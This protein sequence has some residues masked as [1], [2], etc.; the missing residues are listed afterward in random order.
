MNNVREMEIEMELSEAVARETHGA[1][2][3]L[4]QAISY[5][6][7]PGGARV[8]PKLCLAVANACNPTPPS[9]VLGAAVATEFLHCA[10]LVHDDLPCLDNAAFRRGRPSVHA[11]FG[12]ATALLVGDALISMAFSEIAIAAQNGPFAFRA[13]HALSMSLGPSR[14]LIA[15]QAWEAEKGALVADVHAAKTGSLFRVA[16]G[17][18]ALFAGG[19]ESAFAKVGEIVGLIYQAGDDLADVVATSQSTGKP[20]RQDMRFDRP[21]IV[22]QVGI[23]G[24]RDLISK[25]TV[26]LQASIPACAGREQLRIDVLDALSPIFNLSAQVES[27]HEQSRGFA[28]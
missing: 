18:G 24:T 1:P 13:V 20:S 22:R 28:S 4:A 6:V 3:Q 17:L 16:C 7:F 15:G 10:S 12:E 26:D 25:L 11:A 2:P 8:R 21:S 9:S 19:D 14:G 27:M 5:A 23:K